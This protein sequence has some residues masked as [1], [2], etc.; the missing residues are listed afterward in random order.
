M[1]HK[2][3][4]AQAKRKRALDYQTYSGKLSAQGDNSTEHW[5]SFEELKDKLASLVAGLP[6]KCRITYQLSREAGLSQKQIAQ[7]STTSNT[8]TTYPDSMWRREVSPHPAK[9]HPASSPTQ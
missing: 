4:N 3:I 2:V 9:A 8:S 5:L 6:E 7:K 1:K